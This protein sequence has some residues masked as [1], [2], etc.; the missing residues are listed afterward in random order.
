[1]EKNRVEVLVATMHQSDFSKVEEMRIES[2]VLFANQSNAT[3]FRYKKFDAFTARMITTDTRGVGKNRNV[4]LNYAKGEFL[5]LADDDV[6]YNKG[7]TEMVCKAFSEHPDADAIIFNLNVV[8]GTVP[9][10]HNNKSGRVRIYNALNYGAV[11]IA[12]RLDSIQHKRI[13]FSTIFGPGGIYS[14]GEDSL[15]IRDMLRAGLRIY[16]SEDVIATVNQ[17]TSTWFHG[18]DE[19]YIYDK[20][21]LYFALFPNMCTLLCLQ[22]LLRHPEV[23]KGA[24]LTFDQALKIMLQGKESIK[25]SVVNCIK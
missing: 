18:Y 15:F 10:R 24:E 14:S 7:Y 12:V 17:K 13:S 8:D 3:D 25:K 5:L 20:G 4:A 21:A 9:W 23:Y 6:T 11:R 16:T 1:M 2:D 19:K 22:Y